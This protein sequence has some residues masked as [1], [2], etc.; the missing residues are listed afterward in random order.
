MSQII[1]RCTPEDWRS[2]A[3]LRMA[4]N[5]HAG[6]RVS[7]FTSNPI[8][9]VST[10]YQHDPHMAMGCWQDGVIAA[11]ICAYAGADYWVLDLMISSGDPKQLQACLEQLLQEFEA[12]G[13]Y[14]FWYA[15]PEK[16]ARAYRSFWKSGAPSLRKYTIEDVAVI[17]AR[18]KVDDQFIWN[19]ILHECVVPVPLLLRR[20]YVA[21]VAK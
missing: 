5:T 2:M 17:P 13:K 18:K 3:R 19:N 7:E 1:R 10:R 16:W 21:E 12:K 14:Q 9:S 6:S 11:Y 15:F 20:S 8:S 4:R